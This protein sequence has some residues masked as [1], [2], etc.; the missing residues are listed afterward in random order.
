MNY[1]FDKKICFCQKSKMEDFPLNCDTLI[2][3]IRKIDNFE[4][5]VRLVNSVNKSMF[6]QYLTDRSVNDYL[7]T[8]LPNSF[9]RLIKLTYDAG[10][11]FKKI[12]SMYKL[13]QTKIACGGEY[14]T[15][16]DLKR[17]MWTCGDNSNGQLG[18]GDKN[19]RLVLT[20]V[21]SPNSPISVACG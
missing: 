1:N 2:E 10:D 14:T 17:T 8:F 21:P 3:I 19:D 18:L 5:I 11:N 7:L 15:L 9:Q 16:I 6:K 12:V 4:Q 20:Q 13:S